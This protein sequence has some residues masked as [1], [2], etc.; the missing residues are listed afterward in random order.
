MAMLVALRRM[1][2][3]DLTAHGFRSTFRNWCAE[4]THYPREQA[5]SALAH[6]LTNK[7]EAAYQRGDLFA[8]RA[9]LMQ[10]WADWCDRTETAAVS[11]IKRA[12]APQVIGGSMQ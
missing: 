9:K 10:A 6:V 2:R 7:V 1:G 3:D 11:P 8:K 12:Q 5:E 4:A